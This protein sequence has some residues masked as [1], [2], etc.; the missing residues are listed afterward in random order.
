M[1]RTPALTVSALALTLAFGVVGCSTSPAEEDSSPAAESSSSES[2]SSSSS[3]AANELDVAPAAGAL[4]TG[5]GYTYN[6]P[7]GWEL[8][9]KSIAP[10]TDTAAA[11]VTTTTDFADNVNVILSPAGALTPEQVEKMA[12]QELEAA[13]ASDVT[14]EDRVTFGGKES[15]HISA[16]M[17]A[18]GATYRIHQYY[19]TNNDQTY[20]VTF[21][22]GT[23]VADTEAVEVSESIL[24]SWTWS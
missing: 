2:P 5:D 21:S 16:G 9:D 15:A 17:T 23:Q 12:A 6:V 18:S 20:I 19:G 4:I 10:G 1:R 8:Q 14:V 13:G 7:E 3:S 22:F 24:A 11:D